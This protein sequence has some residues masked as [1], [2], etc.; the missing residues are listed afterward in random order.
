[1]QAAVLPMALIRLVDSVLLRLLLLVMGF[2]N[3]DELGAR[4]SNVAP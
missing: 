1:V 3:I 2:W 4:I